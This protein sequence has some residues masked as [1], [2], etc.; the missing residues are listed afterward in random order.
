MSYNFN[1][2]VVEGESINA[3]IENRAL[4][5]G[6]SIF[7]SM[8]FANGRINFW[9][10]HYFRLMA[11]MRLVRMEIPLSYSPEY[12][13]QEVRN[14]LKAN[15]LEQG[16]A[17]VRL[18]VIRKSG[19][20][21]TPNTNEVD[22]LIT[23]SALSENNYTL[24]EKG[25]EVDLYKDFYLPKSM[26]SNLKTGSSIFYVL[27]SVFKTENDLDECFL[28]NDTKELVEAISAN[29]FLRKEN[30]VYTPP[31]SSGCL[32]GVMRKQVLSILPQMDYTVVEESINPFELQRADEVFLT[33]STKGIQWVKNYRKKQYNNHLAKEL[34]QKLNVKVAL[35]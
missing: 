5:Y 14:T 13:E 7:E 29:V 3:S 28:L 24:N 4:R 2:V 31:L 33:N 32:K 15:Q 35:V 6:D 8:R 17:R 11:S 18:Q 20:L 30:T 27:A 10:D 34:V 23:T 19:G 9:E 21:Y 26:L 12:L 16:A 22:L 1:G 25:L